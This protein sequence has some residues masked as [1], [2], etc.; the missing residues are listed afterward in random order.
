MQRTAPSPPATAVGERLSKRVMQLRGCSRSE[1]ERFIA[2][3]WVT[4]D[5][6]VVET[7]QHR[8]TKE[9]VQVSEAATSLEPAA[10]TLVLHK[11]PGHRQPQSLLIPAN[12]WARPGQRTTQPVLKSHLRKLEAFDALEPGASGLLVY[13]QD[14]R[15]QRKLTEDMAVMEHEILIDIGGE[16]DAGAL[17][18]IERALRETSKGLPSAKVS[19]GSSS[20]QRSRLRL[21]VKGAHPGLAAHLC[22]LAGL[23]I[24]ALRRN[25][26]GRVALGDLP[27]GHWRYLEPDERF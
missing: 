2:G 8:V 27:E 1:A 24:T 6:Q 26:L 21:A 16:V 17:A 3:G 15:V 19:V 18:P 25:R 22:Q 5:G 10:V 7:P 11:P 13:T 12:R 23:T 20:V 14:W 9:V 4:V